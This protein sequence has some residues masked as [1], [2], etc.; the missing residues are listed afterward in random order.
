MSTNYIFKVKIY[1]IFNLNNYQNVYGNYIRF[2][3]CSK[4][5]VG[6]IRLFVGVEAL[7]PLLTNYFIGG[8]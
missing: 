6:W 2:L 4:K 5:F 8:K 7:Y 3:N 1:K